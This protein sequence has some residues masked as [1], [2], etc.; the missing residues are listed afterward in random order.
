VVSHLSR[1][2]DGLRNLLVWAASGVETP[3]YPS[4]ESRAAAIEVGAGR[5]ADTL[6]ADLTTSAL[7]LDLAVG[8]LAVPGALDRVVRVGAGRP[9]TAAVIPALRLR[10]LEIHHV[11]LGAGYTVDDWSATFVRATLDELAPFFVTQRDSAIGWLVD[12]DTG[13]RWQVGRGESQATGMANHLLAWLVGRPH[14]G[15][16]LADGSMPPEPPRWT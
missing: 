7:A 8:L 12:P 11:D 5:S 10:E 1:N 13:L 3:M 16:R 6:T 2:A 4:A 9:A 14:E 15:V